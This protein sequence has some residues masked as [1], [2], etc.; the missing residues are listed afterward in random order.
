MVNELLGPHVQIVDDLLNRLRD[1]QEGDTASPR[2]VGYS[3]LTVV[4]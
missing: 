1:I 3:H 4:F 2:V